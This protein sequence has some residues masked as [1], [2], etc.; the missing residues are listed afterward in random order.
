MRLAPDADLII[1]L[2]AEILLKLAFDNRKF[3]KVSHSVMQQVLSF[4]TKLT[5]F[6]CIDAVTCRFT[7]AARKE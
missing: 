2:L 7:I 6:C 1:F 4:A 3:K 5:N